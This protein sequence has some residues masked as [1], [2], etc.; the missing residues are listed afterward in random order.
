MLSAS[1]NLFVY[2]YVT[3]LQKKICHYA[4]GL[5]VF[6]QHETF[7]RLW[8]SSYVKFIQQAFSAGWQCASCFWISTVISEFLHENTA[9]HLDVIQRFAN[10]FITNALFLLNLY[11]HI[12]Q[13]LSKFVGGHTILIQE[14]SL[15]ARSR[16]ASVIGPSQISFPFVQEP[17]YRQP[18]FFLNSS[19]N[20]LIK[21]VAYLLIW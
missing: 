5:E 3:L 16:K 10:V 8:V 2:T 1:I 12:D 19:V 11:V 13:R 6:W 21:K 14:M 9:V 4:Q 20:N 17:K 7:A 15:L 18:H